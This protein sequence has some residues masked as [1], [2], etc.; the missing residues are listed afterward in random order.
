MPVKSVAKFILRLEPDKTLVLIE[1]AY[2]VY[3][4]TV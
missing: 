3:G 4:L 1:S 2:H